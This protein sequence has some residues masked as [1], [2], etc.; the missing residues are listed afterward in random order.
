MLILAMLFRVNM[1][2]ILRR[3]N[4]ILT[5]LLW[6]YVNF[7]LSHFDVIA[8]SEVGFLPILRMTRYFFRTT[9]NLLERI[10]LIIHMVV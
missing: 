8:L 10:D 6:F 3:L 7:K 1:I 4:T 2:H 9:R 5:Y